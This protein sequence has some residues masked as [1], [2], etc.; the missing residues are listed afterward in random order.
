M[1]TDQDQ[2]FSLSQIN[3]ALKGG[4]AVVAEFATDQTIETVYSG[5]IS[6]RGVMKFH[7]VYKM[8]ELNESMYNELVGVRFE[9]PYSYFNEYGSKISGHYHWEFFAVQLYIEL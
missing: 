5:A 4:F 7:V 9:E 8:T 1:I 3:R 2:L 6:E